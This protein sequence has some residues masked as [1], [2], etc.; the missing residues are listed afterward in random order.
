MTQ[1]CR[2]E[3][4]MPGGIELT[5]EAERHLDIDKDAKILSV[6][7]G[8]GELECYLAE[9][10]GC[11]IIGI[12]ITESFI[13]RARKKAAAKGLDSLIQFKIGDG[14]FIEF[15]KEMF[16]I[17]FCSGALC[18]F[19][20]NGLA[21]FHRVLKRGGKAAIIDAVW[22]NGQVPRDIEQCWTEG[23]A[24]ILTLE[25]NRRAFKNYG[26]KVL[27]SQAYDKPSWWEAYYDD[28]GN[29][30]QWQQERANYRAH[31]DYI[32]L[33]LFVMEKV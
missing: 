6:A 3:V 8:T 4:L 1:I 17:V 13:A 5:L 26:F 10:Y 18:E 33:G 20:D 9:K 23:T 29:A 31:K 25:G 24:K 2:Q 32:A 30:P 19:F 22:K 21:E 12:D 15:G 27:F 14:N 28:R 16:D 11:T 7:C